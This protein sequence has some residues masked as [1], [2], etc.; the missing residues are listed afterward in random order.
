MTVAELIEL[1][2]RMPAVAPVY[3]ELLPGDAQPAARVDLLP[4]DDS[5]MLVLLGAA[6][7]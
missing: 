1:L 7:P 3:V 6:Q 4:V 2:Q 5:A